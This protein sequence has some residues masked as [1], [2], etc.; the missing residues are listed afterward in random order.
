MKTNRVSIA[1]PH[2]GKRILQIDRLA[3]NVRMGKNME[4]MYIILLERIA[5]SRFVEWASS[6]CPK[7]AMNAAKKISGY[8]PFCLGFTR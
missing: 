7:Q 3:L 2:A 4:P 8:G 6:R 1:C 5:W